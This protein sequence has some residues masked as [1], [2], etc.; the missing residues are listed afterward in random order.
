MLNLMLDESTILGYG[1]IEIKKIDLDKGEAIVHVKKSAF[2]E[3]YK[4]LY[5]S[6]DEPVCNF[7]AGLVGGVGKELS[8][9]DVVAEETKCI[10]KGDRY[11][12]F[13]IEP[14][15]KTD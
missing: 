11:C 9:K 3:T 1:K 6:S 15:E 5:G 13:V 2:G 4:R 7:L 10:A 8:G 14:K 12:E